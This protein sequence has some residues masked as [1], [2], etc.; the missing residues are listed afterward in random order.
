MW[1]LLTISSVTE[2]TRVS[3]AINK[4]WKGYEMRMIYEKILVPTVVFR[5]EKWGFGYEG[6]KS[7]Y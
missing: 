2:G 3:G 5:G 7:K 1:V 6:K 4:V